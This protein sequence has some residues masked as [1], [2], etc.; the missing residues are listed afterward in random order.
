VSI[1]G[2]VADLYDAARPGYPTHLFDWLGTLGGRTVMDIG[3]GTGIATVELLAR[4]AKVVAVDT[5]PEMLARAKARNGAVVALVS[6]GARLPLRDASTDCACFAQSWHWMEKGRRVQE[7]ARILRA[8]GLWA[9]WWSQPRADGQ[10]WFEHF[11]EI[12]ESSCDGIHR[13]QRD[14][15]WG[16][17][18]IDSGLFH[19]RPVAAEPWMRHI[20][21]RAWL[22]DLRTQSYVA[23]LDEV[24]RTALLDEM[25]EVMDQDFPGGR[26]VIPYDTTLWS[27][28]RR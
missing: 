1:F 25:A 26:M 16:E 22:M 28:I 11:W 7:V 19:V 17:E 20:D 6:D 21:V 13:E 4:G 18:L 12:I 3:A 23:A 27:A 2:T 14:A 10:A 5:S 24:R 15:D 8:G 9:A